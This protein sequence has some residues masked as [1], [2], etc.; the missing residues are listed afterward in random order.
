MA[1]HA[2]PVHLR[3]LRVAAGLLLLAG[4]VAYLTPRALL[5]QVQAA[6]PA[7]LMAA[8]AAILLATVLGT[9]ALFLLVG[10]DRPL[11]FRGFLGAY[12]MAWGVGLVVPGR[13]GDVATL[14]ALMQRRGL[15]WPT[16]LG[17][18][19]LDKAISLVVLGSFAAWELSVRLPGLSRSPIAMLA[20]ASGLGL[21]LLTIWIALRKVR[22]GDS[23]G[24]AVRA[25]VVETVRSVRQH[26][27]RTLANLCLTVLKFALIVLAY[28]CVFRALGQGQLEYQR[29]LP[30][31]ATSA[32][33][34]YI[35]V[36]FNGLGTVEFAGIALFGSAGVE[37]SAVLT[38]YLLLR[39]MVLAIAWLPLLAALTFSRPPRPA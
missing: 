23:P 1:Q 35:P 19:L 3:W 32:L 8:A 6:E 36:S 22:P 4:L 15:H 17:R 18:I 39:V 33:V 28:W 21:V 16:G 29:A 2:S 13:I 9:F 20:L 10:R 25:T 14:T 34:A 7:W 31:V 12:W 11:P 5:A 26:P 30:L 24:G 27:G 37:Q 38:A